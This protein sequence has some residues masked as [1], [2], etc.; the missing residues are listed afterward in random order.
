MIAFVA[1]VEPCL[2]TAI[3]AAGTCAL[4]SASMTPSMNLGG[5][6]GTFALRISPVSRS[7][8]TR[9]ENVPPMST[10]TM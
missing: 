5:V 7:R 8:Q 10:A 1:I 6:E 9:S 3:S 4:S 2:K